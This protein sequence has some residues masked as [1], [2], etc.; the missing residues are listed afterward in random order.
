MEAIVA[1]LPETPPA[2]DAPGQEDGAKR[3]QIMEGARSAFL[4]G[5]DAASM[6]DIARTA[7]VSKG[8]LYAYFDSKEALFEAMI[9]EER[10]QQ[11]ERQCLFPDE[12]RDPGA[13]LR[14]YGRR[15]VAK[16]TRPDSIAQIRVVAAAASKFPRLGQA[17]YEAGPFF[18][19]VRL[20]ERLDGF[21]AEGTL[22]IDDT[23]LA[24]RQFIDLC[25]G[26][27]LKRLLFAVVETLTP[28]EIGET[29]DGS[30]ALFLKAYGAPTRG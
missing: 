26:D 3:R 19:I 20:R 13:A 29:V 25:L 15:V 14:I 16:V 22:A 11:P 23:E 4:A 9:R 2:G 6:N 17:F 27:A 5:F 10:A 21:V 8:T 30:V 12:E 28:D 7:G 1:S 18:G 24:A